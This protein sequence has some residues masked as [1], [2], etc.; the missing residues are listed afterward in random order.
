MECFGKLLDASSHGFAD[1]ILHREVE[2]ALHA[3]VGFDAELFH[4]LNRPDPHMVFFLTSALVGVEADDVVA[5]FV[6]EDGEAD[7]GFGLR[8]FNPVDRSAVVE[9]DAPGAAAHTASPAAH[10]DVVA[11]LE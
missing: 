10:A 8:G 1:R 5:D 3:L 6:E 2:A 11:L 9:K 4:L 7:R